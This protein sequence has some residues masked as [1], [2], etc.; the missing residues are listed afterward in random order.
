MPKV[1]GILGGISPASTAA[2]Y[3]RIIA[4]YLE[5]NG[6]YHFPEIVLYSLD[7]QRF[8]DLEHRQDPEELIAEIV[9]GIQVLE[10]AGADFAIMAANSPH[11]VFDQVS[12]RVRIPLLSI[13][14]PTAREAARREL[15]SLLLLGIKFTMQSD[16]YAKA[17]A[18]YG[19]KVGVPS[20][21]H[22]DE[23]EALIFGELVR[24]VISDQSRGRLLEII[25]GYN[26]GGVILGC[27]ELPLLL[28]ARHTSVPLLDTLALHA[29]AALEY[30]MGGESMS[31]LAAITHNGGADR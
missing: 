27:T 3:Q 2:C 7:F 23:I 13:V 8:T 22:Q 16:F 12:P 26:P 20:L 14:D 31:R 28:Q 18:R 24:N 29:D 11:A 21:E 4:R 17:L 15:K 25:R 1:I 9:R 30:A 5:R 19:I 6:D 10:R